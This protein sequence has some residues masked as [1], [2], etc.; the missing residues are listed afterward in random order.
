MATLIAL[1]QL[2]EGQAQGAQLG[3][4][5]FLVIRF[6]AE[7]YVYL[8]RCPHLGI[9]LDWQPDQFLDD[10]GELIRCA[11]HGALFT[12]DDGLCISGPCSGQ[13][14]QPVPHKVLDGNVVLCD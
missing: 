14:L 8:N 5:R 10:D 7:V 4:S 2:A 1:S 11:T 6:E 3:E 12:I 13:Y 9:P